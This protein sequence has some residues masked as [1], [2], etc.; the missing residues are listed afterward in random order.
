MLAISRILHLSNHHNTCAAAS[1]PVIAE[2]FL[3]WECFMAQL[4]GLLRKLK[5]ASFQK[6]SFILMVNLQRGS[7]KDQ[8]S[9][10]F[11]KLSLETF[12]RFWTVESKQLSF[13]RISAFFFSLRLPAA[14]CHLFDQKP[15]V[16]RGQQKD[17]DGSIIIITDLAV[18]HA[19]PILTSFCQSASMLQSQ[20]PQLAS[21]EPCAAA[22]RG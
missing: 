18:S 15:F 19:F 14:L 6:A 2:W 17:V 10:I 12:L 21:T 3:F 20:E 13:L 7:S 11:Y 16:L 9:C 1:S 4:G 5:Q 8:V 22:A